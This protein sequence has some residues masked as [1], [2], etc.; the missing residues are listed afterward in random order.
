MKEGQ[1]EECMSNR[2]VLIEEYFLHKSSFCQHTVSQDFSIQ[3][4]SYI[5]NFDIWY[6][7]VVAIVCFE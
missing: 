1:G 2:D 4:A 5:L 7:P 6:K 3:L